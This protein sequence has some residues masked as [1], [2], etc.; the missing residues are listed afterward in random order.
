[1]ASPTFAE[2]WCAKH[3]IAPADFAA[4]VLPRVLH[5][6]ARLVMPLCRFFNANHFAADM[7][8]VRAAGALRRV[9]D[10]ADEITDFTHHPANT[11]FLRRVLRLRVS[12]HR[13]R[14]LM[15]AT[16]PPHGDGGSRPPT[17]SA[18]PFETPPT[19]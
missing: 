10:L 4:A 9:R 13:L 5:L 6:P 15:R 19:A 11:G 8:L 2:A 18:A 7:D 16:L 3:G 17:G 12:T 1:M 14:A